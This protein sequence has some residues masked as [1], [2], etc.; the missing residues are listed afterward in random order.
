MTLVLL[1]ASDA[2]SLAVL[3]VSGAQRLVIAPGAFAAPSNASRIVLR[4]PSAITGH[5]PFAV[6]P[7]AA[8]ISL[9]ETGAP[10]PVSPDGVFSAVG[11]PGVPVPAGPTEIQ[12]VVAAIRAAGPARAVPKGRAGKA[13][14]PT[15][16]EFGK[17]AA[18]TVGVG[19][20]LD[21]P[22]RTSFLRVNY[23]GDVA[24]LEVNGTLLTDHQN[25]GERVFTVGL[26]RF[27]GLGVFDKPRTLS[28]LPLSKS[29]PVYLPSPPSFADGNDTALKLHSVKVDWAQDVELDVS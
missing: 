13:E 15:D 22:G 19:S 28:I 16:E 2:E 20:G 12:P 7:P 1:S 18:W 21:A 11:G 14:E 25:T 27:R 24:R 26:T 8:A 17:A 23:T 5:A 4:V 10:L 29:A 6:F 9:A 3:D